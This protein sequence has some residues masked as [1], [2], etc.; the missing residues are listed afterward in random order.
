MSEWRMAVAAGMV[1]AAACSSAT[2]GE[3]RHLHAETIRDG[4]VCR[5]AAV[6]VYDRA[7]LDGQPAHVLWYTTRGGAYPRHALPLVYVQDAGAWH[8]IDSGRSPADGEVVPRS[9]RL[10]KL[11]R[12]SDAGWASNV[13]GARLRDFIGYVPPDELGRWR[14]ELR[15]MREKGGRCGTSGPKR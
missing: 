6:A 5:H 11:E 10:E 4:G 13:G 12:I 1:L 7:T 2:L 14:R 15:K 8:A 3:L 9:R